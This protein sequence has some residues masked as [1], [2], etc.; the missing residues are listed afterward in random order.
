MQS[1]LVVLVVILSSSIVILTCAFHGKKSICRILSV[2]VV[3]RVP[4]YF[5]SVYCRYGKKHIGIS[6]GP[7]QTFAADILL[8]CADLEMGF[9]LRC[10]KN[11]Q[12]CISFN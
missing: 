8:I 1:Q 12:N 10:S 5:L 6:C 3:Q 2:R 9:A 7:L 4:R 11:K